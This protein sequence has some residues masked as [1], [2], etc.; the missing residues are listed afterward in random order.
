MLY[1]I[2]GPRRVLSSELLVGLVVIAPNQVSNSRS[3]GAER[4]RL[5]RYRRPQGLRR[6]SIP[7]HVTH[8]QNR[9]Q[10]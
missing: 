9:L 6:V 2:R 8:V 3:P 1:A 5:Y 7:L 4:M 10:Y